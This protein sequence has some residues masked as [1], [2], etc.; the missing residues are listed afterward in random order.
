M[1]LNEITKTLLT[2]AFFFSV[3]GVFAQ[4]PEDPD[5]ELWDLPVPVLSYYF[6]GQS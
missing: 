1:K 6:S 2:L 4:L 3:S 5:P